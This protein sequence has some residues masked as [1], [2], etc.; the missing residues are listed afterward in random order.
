MIGTLYTTCET[1]QWQLRWT[2]VLLVISKA[3][4]IIFSQTCRDPV[5]IKTL[6]SSADNIMPASYVTGQSSHLSTGISYS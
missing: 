2:N 3:D 5:E 4:K 1:L 6:S